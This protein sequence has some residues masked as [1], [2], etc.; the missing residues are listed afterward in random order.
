MLAAWLSTAEAFEEIGEIDLSR[1]IAETD[2]VDVDPNAMIDAFT[3]GNR[4][5][6]VDP[7]EVEALAARRPEFPRWLQELSEGDFPA[8]V[9]APLRAQVSST[10]L[11]C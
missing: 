7:A 8:E 3:R 5:G 4:F 1:S 9:L 6:R 10:K 11:G 2:E